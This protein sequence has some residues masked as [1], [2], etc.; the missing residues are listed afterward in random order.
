MRR[1]RLF[2]ASGALLAWAY[3]GFPALVLLRGALRPRPYAAAAHTPS[4]AVVVAAHNE[5]ESIEHKIDNLASLDYP[6][7]RLEVIIA[8]D[9]STD[10]TDEAVR[11]RGAPH[12]RLLSLSR[13]GK[14]AALNAAVATISADV[15][16]FTDANSM[17]RPDAL[18]A[19]MRPLADP[20]VGAVAGD[21][22]YTGDETEGTAVGELDYWSLDRALKRAQ[23]ASGSIVGATGALYA[24]RRELVAPIPD[25]V[26]DDFYVSL[27]VVGRGARLVFEPE[28][29]A[30]EPVAPSAAREFRR[31][32]RV[33]TRGLR[34]MFVMRR[35]LNPRRHG[36]FAIQLL[37]QK[38]LLRVSV[39]PLG[40][41]ALTSATL[42][43]RGRVYQIA[44][45]GQAV[46]F[47]LGLIGLAAP[48]SRLARRRVVA[49][50]AYFCLI[51]AAQTAA[52]WNLARR[53]T[54]NRWE[55]QRRV[56]S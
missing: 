42:V 19:L 51:N 31:R 18:Q 45:A 10:G 34:C 33:L 1:E 8:S 15:V 7:E 32:T 44:A 53:R 54:V 39:V 52:L 24:V 12:V 38:L 3:A 16:V 22:R 29:V 50:P 5:I 14:A 56:G 20:D 40:V 41:I 11:R 48:R 47:G 27:A 37:S 23:S 30:H 46:L 49:L 9:G 35:L 55:P 25:G 4:V 13:R 36:F 6:R 21:Q 28:A 2:W 26:P 17:L 43:R